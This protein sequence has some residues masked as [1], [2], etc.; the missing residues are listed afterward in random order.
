[1]ASVS[2]PSR[3]LRAPRL[4]PRAVAVGLVAVSLLGCAWLWLR[5]SSVVAVEEVRV[6]G[7]SGPRAGDLRE[8]L[9]KA[10]A[11]MTTLHVRVD[12]LRE[13]AAPFPKVADLRVD[14]D[15]PHGLTIGVVERIPVAA[16]V[17]GDRRVAVGADGTL[18][19]GEPAAQLATVTA[20]RLPSQE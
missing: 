3:L 9:T 8:T 10:A 20:P 14:R 6:V 19:P 5:D 11:D 1:M 18:L 7:A 2:L 15:L 17:A 4:R 12:A 13:A 16:L